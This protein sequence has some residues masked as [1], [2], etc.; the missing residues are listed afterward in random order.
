MTTPQGSNGETSRDARCSSLDELGPGMRARVCEHPG[1]R[2]LR[3]RLADLGLVGGT[4]LEV[5]RCAPLGG[6]IEIELRGYRLV[7][8]RSEA[9]AICVRQGA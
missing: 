3:Q 4:A 9:A 2:P 1:A 5:L 8:R 6:P 7:L